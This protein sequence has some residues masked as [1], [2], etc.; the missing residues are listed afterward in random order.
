MEYKGGFWGKNLSYFIGVN[1]GHEEVGIGFELEGGLLG[2]ATWQF[3]IGR[4]R[5][6][7]RFEFLC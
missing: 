4:Y 2:H 6:F 7:S 5:I 3:S 1:F